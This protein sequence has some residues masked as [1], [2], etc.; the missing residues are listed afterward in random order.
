MGFETTGLLDCK[1]VVLVF[2]KKAFS[3][4]VCTDLS[5]GVTVSVVCG[6]SKSVCPSSFSH[7]RKPL[8]L[9]LFCSWQ[10]SLVFLPVRPALIS[11]QRLPDS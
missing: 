1:V 8:N 7:A 11:R 3:L 9:R 4:S 6:R 5:H 10:M 2:E